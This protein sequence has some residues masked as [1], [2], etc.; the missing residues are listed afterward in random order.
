VGVATHEPECLTVDAWKRDR[1][2][3]VGA[4][5]MIPNYLELPSLLDTLFP[6]AH[7]VQV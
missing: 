7:A 5:F 2:K 3:S 4:D 1:L 6:Q